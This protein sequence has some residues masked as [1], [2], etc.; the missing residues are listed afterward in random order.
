M[1][2]VLFLLAI[3]LSVL[4]RYTDSNYPFGIFKLFLPFRSTSVHPG[5]SGVRITRSS[6]LCVCFVERCISLCPFSFDHCVV[7]AAS[8]YGFWLPLWYLQT[9]LTIYRK[10]VSWFFFI[11]KE[12][13]SNVTFDTI[14]STI[15]PFWE[16]YE[17]WL[18]WRIKVHVR[19]NRWQES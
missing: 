18:Q 2:F 1:S 6:V 16:C 5:F 10:L 15:L 9:I 13:I 19:E 3:V 7:C 8:I 4:L 14:E 11:S 17:V 12:W